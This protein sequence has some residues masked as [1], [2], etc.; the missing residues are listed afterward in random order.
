MISL[1]GYRE[2]TIRPE[3]QYINYI[4][5]NAQNN[6]EYVI[7]PGNFRMRDDIFTNDMQFGFIQIN[8]TQ[9]GQNHMSP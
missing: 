5:L 8:L 9:T 1:W 6:G 2:T 4:E 3:F 7:S